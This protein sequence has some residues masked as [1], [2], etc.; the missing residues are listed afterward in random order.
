M[1]LFAFMI[2]ALILVNT[3]SSEYT[4]RESC[5]RWK[6]NISIIF[7]SRAIIFSRYIIFTHFSSCINMKCVF[8]ARED[9]RDWSESSE[10]KSSFGMSNPIPFTSSSPRPSRNVYFKIFIQKFFFLFFFENYHSISGNIK[11]IDV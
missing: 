1:S 2:D 6:E 9:K 3:L 4:L 7:F 10:E 8:G 5:A 11:Y